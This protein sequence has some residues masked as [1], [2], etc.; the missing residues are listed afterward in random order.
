[1]KKL[2]SLTL[3]ICTLLNLTYGIAFM[4]DSF[5]MPT[6]FAR[7]YK[8]YNAYVFFTDVPMASPN[9]TAYR[10]VGAKFTAIQNDKP[11]VVYMPLT[12]FA[13]NEPYEKEG[14]TWIT[15]EFRIDLGDL[16]NAYKTVY[17]ND[18]T[19]LENLDAFFAHDNVMTADAL[20]TY[21][22]SSGVQGSI[23]HFGKTLDDT[24]A[25]GE[26]YESFADFTGSNIEW[27]RTTKDR[28]AQE[29]YNVGLNFLAQPVG[30]LVPKI[31]GM[32]D[33]VRAER[34]LHVF[35]E[36][37]SIP[38]DATSC[39]FPND[40]VDHVYKWEYKPAHQIVTICHQFLKRILKRHFQIHFK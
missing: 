34:P 29:Y 27:S 2:V 6:K 35:K 33:G 25:W 32:V 11:Y 24:G 39:E 9:T 31:M 17:N 40:F 22:N 21:V 15:T 14:R 1:M 10:T 38:L 28:V 16:Y 3:I 36:N 37:Q 18:A 20:L 5:I 30:K 13:E 12:K 19:A 7:Y 8:E 4:D 26:I 23:D